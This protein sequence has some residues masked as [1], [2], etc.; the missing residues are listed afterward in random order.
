[1]D[2]HTNVFVNVK[3]MSWLITISQIETIIGGKSQSMCATH[4]G[5]LESR[6]DS[7]ACEKF[8]KS[9]E[10]AGWWQGLGGWFG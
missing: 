3:K 6:G 10:R 1:M 8:G 2:K 5:S 9:M 7:G 4:R